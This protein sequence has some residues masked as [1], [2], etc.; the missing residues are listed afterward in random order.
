MTPTRPGFAYTVTARFDDEAVAQAYRAW[1]LRGHLQQVVAGGAAQATLLQLTPT[2]L[3]VRYLFADEAAFRAYEAGPAVPL[4]AEG[5][6]LFPPTRGVTMSRTT[7]TVL[8]T[9]P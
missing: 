8:A 5:A 6:A 7:G 1:L 9:A 2:H 4:R 3:E